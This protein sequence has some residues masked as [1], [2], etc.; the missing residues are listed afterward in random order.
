MR[1]VCALLVMLCWGLAFVPSAVSWN[2]DGQERDRQAA[3][4]A[5]EQS[6]EAL[7]AWVE[8]TMLE[9]KTA[10]SLWQV[11]M[12]LG[13]D[14]PARLDAGPDKVTACIAQ[15]RVEMYRRLGDLQAAPA[16]IRTYPSTALQNYVDLAEGIFVD[17]FPRP[18]A[19]RV[20]DGGEYDQ[21]FSRMEQALRASA[22]V[23]REKV[24][25]MRR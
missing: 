19:G 21:R 3:V 10:V 25:M 16:N 12:A 22:E 17:F 9:C 24:R 11:S 2:P 20:E 15:N 5:Y 14:G 7:H 1:Y 13:S 8:T 18:L 6:F 4:G 23:V